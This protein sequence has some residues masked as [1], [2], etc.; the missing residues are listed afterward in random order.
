MDIRTL[1][2]TLGTT[3]NLDT[4]SNKTGSTNS[5]VA[6]ALQAAGPI[7]LSGLIQN[8][9]TKPGQK[10]L[11]STLKKNHDGSILKNLP[12]F[13]ENAN[14]QEGQKILSHIF[15]KQKKY[16]VD[17]VAQKSGLDTFQSG[18]LLAVL[19]PVIMGYLGKQVKDNKL[20]Q[21]ELSKVVAKA[22]SGFNLKSVLSQFLDKNGNGS[23]VD[24]LLSMGMNALGHKK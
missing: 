19:A 22:N 11:H 3:K 8:T 9:Q 21:E 7:I 2:K 5:A 15:E 20:D 4:L 24:D 14:L 13:L 6:K 17:E 10:A 18:T 23:A 1:V 16:A 12:D